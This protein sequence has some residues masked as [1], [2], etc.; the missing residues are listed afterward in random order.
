MTGICGLTGREADDLES[1]AKTILSLM[2]NR[3]SESR[4]FSQN[5]P[6]G[7]KIVIG[8]CDSTGSQSFAHH[9]VP[10]ALDGVFLGDDARADKAGAAG[11]SRL[12][13]T[14]GAFAFL[15][16]LQDQ[17]IAGRDIVGQKPLYFG[18]TGEG[19]VAFASLKSPLI[20][21]GVREPGPLPPG[22]VIRAS[23]EGYETVSDYALKPPKEEQTGEPEATRNLDEL[24]EEAVSRIVPRGSGIAFSG[25]LDSSLVAHVAK[26]SGL[27]PELISV[28]LKGQQELEHAGKTAKSFGLRVNIRELSSSEILNSLP[29][30]VEIIETADPVI[31]GIS[32]PIY[33]A[34][35]KA[36]ELDLS[37]IAAGQLSDELFGGYGKFEDIAVQD[38][39]NDLGRAM[40]DSVVAASVKDF[41][42]GDKLAVAAGLELCS[43]FA[44]LP[45]VEYVLKLPSSLRVNLTNGKVIR[46]YILRRLAAQLGLPKSVVDRPKKAVQYSSGVQKV[47]LKEAKRKRVSLGRMLESLTR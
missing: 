40:F 41:D 23:A 27:C 1:K 18:Q 37:F 42:P 45:L 12:I 14:P 34:C 35:Q 30:V 26:S 10:L 21:I 43:P 32:V 3:G 31:V 44:Y 5:A 6:S 39:G 38:G 29:D 47:L 15:T 22:K 13:Q 8:V 33:F 46:K 2:R 9:A 28:G 19:T 25:G 36:R 7:E 11:P 20:S 16:S 4:T 24:F 17:M